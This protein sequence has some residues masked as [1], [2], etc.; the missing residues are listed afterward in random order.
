MRGAAVNGGSS[1][2]QQAP[3]HQHFTNHLCC[4]HRTP[5]PSVAD[6]KY[7][8]LQSQQ[9]VLPLNLRLGSVLDLLCD[10]KEVSL[11]QRRLLCQF[12][13][14]HFSSFTKWPEDKNSWQSSCPCLPRAG[15][16][17]LSRQ[18]WLCAFVFLSPCLQPLHTL[19]TQ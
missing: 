1:G 14:F 3:R 16:T 4:A 7:Q 18:T 5:P 10:P 11:F 13:S 17:G 8:H 12:P 6:R 19:S 15:I 9:P 2:S